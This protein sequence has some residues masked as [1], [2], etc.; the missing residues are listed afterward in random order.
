MTCSHLAQV[1]ELCGGVSEWETVIRERK[2]AVREK[3]QSTA[4]DRVW[5]TRNPR[6]PKE[7]TNMPISDRL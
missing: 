6:S 2:E 1:L 4:G 5:G 7:G 3:V